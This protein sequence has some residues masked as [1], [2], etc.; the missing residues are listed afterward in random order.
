MFKNQINGSVTLRR[1]DTLPNGTLRRN[2]AEIRQKC[3][4]R[5]YREYFIQDNIFVLYLHKLFSKKLKCIIFINI[6]ELHSEF[7]MG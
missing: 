3:Q 2:F 4:K 6:S 7:L 5:F 1:K